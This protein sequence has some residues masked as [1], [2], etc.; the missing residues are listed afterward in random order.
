MTETAHLSHSLASLHL[1]IQTGAVQIVD[2]THV[3]DER[4]PPIRLPPPKVSP[5]RFSLRELSRYDERGQHEYW[6]AFETGEHVGTHFDAPIH[7]HTGRELDDVAAVPVRRLLG[8]AVVLDVSEAC[9]RDPDHL[10]SLEDVQA[11]ERDHGSLPD[12]GWLLI[13]TGW[14]L[15][16]GDERS[17]LGLDDG[18]RPHWP[19][20]TVECARWLAEQTAILGLG[21]DCI[22]TDAACSHAFDPPHPAHHYLHGAGKYGMS[23]LANLHRLP[24]TGALVLAAP[25]RI[26]GGSGSP[27]RAL[28]FVPRAS[29][30]L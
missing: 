14:D 21:I 2:L 12:S 23:L 19:G 7:W 30:E 10:I 20:L 17:Y 3:L 25:L 16:Y 26:G 24:T 9:A 4:T 8:P 13:R 11:F 27:M 29:P 22:G 5:P 28:A 6:N 15:R 1:E 18:D